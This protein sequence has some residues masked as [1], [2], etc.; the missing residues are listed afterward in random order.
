VN[1][2][3]IVK[4]H[5]WQKVGEQS[6]YSKTNAQSMQATRDAADPESHE[7]GM[8]ASSPKTK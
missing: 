3:E 2:T 6:H 5:S 1:V 8:K 4:V 7:P